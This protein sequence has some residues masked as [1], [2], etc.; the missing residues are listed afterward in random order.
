MSRLV[1]AG[2]AVVDNVY[3]IAALPA[4][5]GEA[6]ACANA[7]RVGGGFNM[8]AA[9]RRAGMTVAFAGGHGTGPDGDL[10]RRALA[11]EGIETFL[12]AHPALDSGNCVVLVTDDA[13]R[14][15]VSWPGA[16][17]IL[18]R[19]DLDRVAL[20]PGDWVF[21][22][23]YTLSYPGSSE[24]LAGWIEALPAEVRFVFDPSPVVADIPGSIRQRVLNRADWLSG[25]A[26]E[27]RTIAGGE[28]VWE[29]ALRLLGLC[30]RAAGVLVRRG[31]EGLHLRL[32]GGEAFDVPAFAVEAVDTNGAGDTHIGAFVAALSRGETPRAAA[33]YANA[34][35]AISVT[36]HG[37]DSAPHD[38]E[39]RTFLETRGM[40]ACHPSGKE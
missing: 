23:G 26:A 39:I 14:T 5:G 3:R 9:A 33:C 22:S 11:A 24:A 6:V 2:S 34:A 28:D 30:A 8:M 19:G 21:S 36:R 27:A 7:R 16:E 15:F 29:N 10:L 1:H 12:P 25:N 37:G 20:R 40:P 18:E 17:G 31:S 4:A 32:R 35:A 13:E 38:A